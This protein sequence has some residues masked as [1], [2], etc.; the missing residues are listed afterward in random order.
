M[1]LVI[2]NDTHAGVR[3]SSQIFLDNAAKFYSEVFF[4][5]C[6]ENR[7]KQIV[8][9]G[10]Y[11]DNRQSLSVKTLHS[12]RKSFLDPMRDAG[13]R[14]DVILGNHDTVYK[15]TNE[16]N[17]LKEALGYFVKDVYIV[18]EPRVVEYGSLRMALLPWIN[19]SNYARSMDFVQTCSADW[20]GAHLGL[21]G[22]EVMRGVTHEAGMDSKLFSRFDQVLTGHYHCR[23][24]KGNIKYLGSQL[25]FFWSDCGDDKFFY[26][27][28]T[29]TREL[30]PVRNPL[31]LFE[32]VV[33]D[34]TLFDYRN[35]DFDVFR[36][37]FVRITVVSKKDLYVFDK[38]VENIQARGVHDLKIDED[39][40]GFLG[41]NVKDELL[42]VENTE[43]LLDSY[44]DAVETDLDK[45]RIKRELRTLLAQAQTMD[46]Q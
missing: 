6:A 11:Y 1:K 14:M 27:L 25:E 31:T 32:K 5:F 29:E 17:S 16:V 33:Y 41:E 3:N 46:F 37:K 7:I 20:L 43:E 30:T 42:G 26:V 45:N 18:Q 8:H 34:D 24:E 23:S 21:G 10:D 28:D 19:S 13:M 39:L 38:F 2:I 44:V 4:P 35:F 9:L 36:D 40:S 12:N 15:S 22:F